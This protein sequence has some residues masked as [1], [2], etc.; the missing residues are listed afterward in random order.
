MNKNK[1][2]KECL[3]RIFYINFKPVHREFLQN[4]RERKMGL[5]DEIRK[6]IRLTR[7]HNIK[8]ILPFDVGPKVK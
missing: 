7:D 8:K 6:E 1:L 3:K 4:I 2:M 5:N